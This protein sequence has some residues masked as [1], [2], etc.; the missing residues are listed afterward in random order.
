M[1][2]KSLYIFVLPQSF[3]HGVST[4]NYYIIMQKVDFAYCIK[5]RQ[6][7]YGL[8]LVGIVVCRVL[9]AVG[10]NICAYFF[11]IYRHENKGGM[12]A[13]WSKARS[14][15]LRSCVQIHAS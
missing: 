3:L 15:C 4:Y 2:L 6:R 14:I 1:S 12:I 7:L 9:R 11:Y 8:V 5:K 13:N 10:L